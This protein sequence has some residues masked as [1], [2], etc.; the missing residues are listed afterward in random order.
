M[1]F[2]GEIHPRFCNPLKQY[3]KFKSNLLK[4]YIQKGTLKN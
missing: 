3:C 1:A 2:L 4:I